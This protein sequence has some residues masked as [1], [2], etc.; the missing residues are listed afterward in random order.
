MH[1]PRSRRDRDPQL[2]RNRQMSSCG[3][4]RLARAT[5]VRRYGPVPRTNRGSAMAL[6][7]VDAS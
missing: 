7:A 5:T 4:V 1:A 6:R 3:D 2:R